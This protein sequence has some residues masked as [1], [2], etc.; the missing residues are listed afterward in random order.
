MVRGY[1]REK[2][3]LFSRCSGL[4]APL[5]A[6]AGAIVTVIDILNKMLDMDREIAKYENLQ[7]KIA[8]GNMCNLS[9]FVDGYF[10][11]TI[12]PPWLVYIPKPKGVFR[13]CYRILNKGVLLS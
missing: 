5:L 13:E 11:Y 10:D 2:G 7:I 8:K 12:N 9:M 4:Q 3:A 1:Q 6:C